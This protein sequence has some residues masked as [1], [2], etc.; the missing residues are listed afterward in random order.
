MMNEN[1]ERHLEAT[2][3]LFVVNRGENGEA[4]LARS[5]TS[6]LTPYLFSLR[7]YLEYYLVAARLTI[8]RFKI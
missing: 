3:V 2:K 8:A 4:E 6:A 1:D 5:D 7:L